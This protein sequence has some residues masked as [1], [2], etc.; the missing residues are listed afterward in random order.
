M[1]GDTLKRHMKR[2]EN[3]PQSIDVVETVI[4][5]HGS[6]ASYEGGT[7][8][9]TCRCGASLGMCT[10]LNLEELE[11]N[12]ESQVNEFNRKIELGRNFKIILKKHGFNINALPENM[13]EALKTYELYGKNMNMEEINWRGWQKDLREYLDKPCNRKVIWVV[14]EKGNEGKSFFQRN[15]REEF[16]YSRVCRAELNHARDT[17]HI[18]S[19]DY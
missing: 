1:R 5:T 19:K 2:H 18:V 14:G 11:K 10:S 12:V 4:Q 16:G 17:F 8:I 13:K 9:E 6:G 15:I 3:K 7:V